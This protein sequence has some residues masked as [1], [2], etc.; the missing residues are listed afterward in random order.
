[1]EGRRTHLEDN[2]VGGMWIAY[3]KGGDVVRVCSCGG[4]QRGGAVED[5]ENCSSLD[6]LGGG[7]G[8]RAN[9]QEPTADT[10]AA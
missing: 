10:I 2:H 4:E 3:G 7:F 9:T 6:L 8:P 1:V 5:A